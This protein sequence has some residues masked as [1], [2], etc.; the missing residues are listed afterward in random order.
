[1]NRRIF[2]AAVTVALF[3]ILTRVGQVIREPVLAA[4]FGA[5]AE[6][7]AFLT[8]FLI[9]SLL[10]TVIAGSMSAGLIPAFVRVRE[11]VG[12]AAAH[13]LYSS[14]MLC[15][16][17]LL[18]AVTLLMGFFGPSLLPWIGYGFSAEKL[19]LSRRLFLIFLPIL[20]INGLATFWA[21]I[22]NAG[23]R[24]ALAAA[25]PGV[26]P[27]VALAF[28][29]VMGKG[30]GIYALSVGTVMGFTIEAGLLAWNLRRQGY[31]LR[32]RWYGMDPSLRQAIAGF[33]PVMI[34]AFL[35]SSTSLVNQAMAA[36]LG[37][38]NVARLA[39][40]NKV[41]SLA[42]NLAAMALGTAVLPYFS[43]MISRNNW[44]GLRHTLYRYLWLIFLT[45]VPMT[46][47][48]YFFSQPLTRIIFQRGAFTAED[49]QVVS[50][51][52]A[53]YALQIPFY[54]AGILVVRLISSLQMNQILLWAAVVNLAVNI[55]LN[56]LF[57]RFFGVAGIALSTAVV[58]LVSLSFCST[59]LWL[60]VSMARTEGGIGSL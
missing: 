8:A 26:T 44:S 43:T 22:L 50:S 11:Q 3:T 48:L 53:F 20:I 14:A 7:D 38:G 33:A 16:L 46:V 35:M 15:G 23:E 10:I 2:G 54:S 1:M 47:F 56:Y 29:M 42:L 41:I 27:F 40:G 6:M 52:Q 17:G 60:K 24:F 31:S 51:V 37:S 4:W 55:G 12:L 13:R 57:M 39:Y 21:A 32:P 28:L 25:V 49:T 58:Y 19:E 34:G 59:F 45:T 36:K 18:S 5:G 9:P 30:W